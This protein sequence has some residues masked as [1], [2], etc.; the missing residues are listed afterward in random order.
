MA[1]EG[2]AISQL[3]RTKMEN[4]KGTCVYVWVLAKN[5]AKLKTTIFHKKPKIV[6]NLMSVHSV[7]NET[8][9]RWANQVLQDQG[10]LTT[11]K[12]LLLPLSN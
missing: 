7:W 1:P 6:I 9:A 3:F 10:I 4:E 5:A 8:A 2:T 12:K 11:G